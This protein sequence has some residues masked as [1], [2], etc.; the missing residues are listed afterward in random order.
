MLA[1][2]GGVEEWEEWPF[3]PLFALCALF[4]LDRAPVW[5]E[6]ELT[7]DEEPDASR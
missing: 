1:D 6:A 2:V 5:L 7:E 4:V 3:E